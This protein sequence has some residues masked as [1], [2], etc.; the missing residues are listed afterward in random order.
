[1]AQDQTNQLLPVL[2]PTGENQL[3]QGV[4]ALVP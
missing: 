1:M 4:A 3:T 2:T